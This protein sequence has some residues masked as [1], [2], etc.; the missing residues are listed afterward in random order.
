MVFGKCSCVKEGVKEKQDT[1][2]YIYHVPI[3]LKMNI[4]AQEKK[5]ANVN[6]G[7]LWE[8]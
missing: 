5:K 3:L 4:F 8:V 2:F 6:S 1:K 7:H